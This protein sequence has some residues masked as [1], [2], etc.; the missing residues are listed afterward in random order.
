MP[1]RWGR[2]GLRGRRFTQPSLGAGEAERAYEWSKRLIREASSPGPRWRSWHGPRIDVRDIAP[3]STVPTLIVHHRGDK[4]AM[5][6]TPAGSPTDLPGARYVELAGDDHVPW[7]GTAD[8]IARR[9]PGVPHRRPRGRTR[10]TACSR[11]CSSPT[12]SARRSTL[13][14]L[15][16]RRWRRPARAPPRRSRARARARSAAARSTPRATASSPPSTG[17]RGDPLR[18]ARS[19]TPSKELGI[20]IRAGLHTGECELIGRTLGGIAVHIGARVAGRAEARARFSSRARS[21]I[22]SPAR[23]SRSTI[24][25][26]A[27]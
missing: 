23:A 12:S 21:A 19:A 8:E 22:S 11:R 4:S 18:H 25:G 6:R 10:R 27:S 24:A 13:H 17:R 14:E 9:D 2:Y 7:G 1:E 5:S 26:S 3:R 20:D 15:G 16:D